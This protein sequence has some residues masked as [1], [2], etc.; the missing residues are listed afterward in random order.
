M[1][2]VTAT[3]PW[4]RETA[5]QKMISLVILLYWAFSRFLKRNVSF[6]RIVAARRPAAG[7]LQKD[8]HGE[9]REAL[10]LVTRKVDR[11]IFL[12]TAGLNDC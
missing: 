10:R 2:I 5:Y 6:A 7:C 9:E 12:S 1:E 11:I 8:L 3:C 4:I